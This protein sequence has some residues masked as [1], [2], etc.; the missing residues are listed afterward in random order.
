MFLIVHAFYRVFLIRDHPSCYLSVMKNLSICA[1][2]VVLSACGAKSSGNSDLKS[3]EGLA[4]LCAAQTNYQITSPEALPPKMKITLS[5]DGSDGRILFDEC[6]PVQYSTS[7]YKI[8]RSANSGII[9][10]NFVGVIQGNLQVE[11]TDLGSD[12]K[13]DGIFYLNEN[14]DKEITVM[15]DDPA[16]PG[17]ESLVIKL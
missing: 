10:G 13:N 3:N 14:V 7:K 8:Q 9:E 5:T 16:K 1:L 15:S 11:I 4:C 6:L 17:L 2:L 12:C